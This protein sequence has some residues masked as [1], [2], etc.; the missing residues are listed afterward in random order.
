M[1]ILGI[2][3]AA[4]DV[5]TAIDTAGRVLGKD[6]KDISKTVADT[7]V[8]VSDTSAQADMYKAAAS[9][10]WLSF[11]RMV[12]G[13]WALVVATIIVILAMFGAAAPLLTAL[14]QIPEQLW[15]LIEI[16]SGL[17]V[18]GHAAATTVQQIKK[19]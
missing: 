13:F 8:V 1:D 6:A 17:L 7:A 19:K 14:K 2:D 15:T 12:F 3:K 18:A 11:E 10:S 5:S 9:N 4:T 16:N